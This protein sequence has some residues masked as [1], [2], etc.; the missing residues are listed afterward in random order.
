MKFGFSHNADLVNDLLEGKIKSSKRE[1]ND[2]RGKGIPQIANNSQKDIFKRA[3]I[4]SNDVKI[5]LKSRR[6]EK[7]SNDFHGTLLYW[8]L[9]KQGENNG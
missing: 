1:D 4:I 2:I 6:T 3:F 5:D 7:L 8:E 9:T